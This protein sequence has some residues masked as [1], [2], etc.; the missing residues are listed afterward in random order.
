[1]IAAL[2]KHRVGVLYGGL[3]RER[4]VSLRSGA[5]VFAA[6]QELGLNAVLIDVNTDIAAR[7][8]DEKVTL[9]YIILHGKYGEDGCIQGL[10]ECM[11]IPYTGSGVL[12]S[13]IAMNKLATKRFLQQRGIPVPQCIRICQ[14]SPEKSCNEAIDLLGFPLVVKPTEEG[15]SIAVHIVHTP[16][17][18]LAKSKELVASYHESIIEEYVRGKEITTGILG[19]GSAA[20]ALPI[21]GLEPLGGKEFY[22]YEEEDD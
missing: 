21:L 19:T 22:D 1:M 4:D 6:C 8:R 7:L 15:S 17:D 14:N 20:F 18:L 9:A 2:Q 5:N 12:T 16:E 13:A 3:S 11:G 10:L